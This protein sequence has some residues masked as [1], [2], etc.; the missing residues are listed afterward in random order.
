MNIS[1][2]RRKVRLRTRIATFLVRHK[3]AGTDTAPLRVMSS[4]PRSGT[5]WLKH[6][7]SQAMGVDP[8][9]RRINA[10]DP[11][12]LIEALDLEAPHR[13][14]YDHFD[15]DLH[16]T[17]LTPAKYPRLKVVLL[18]R[19]PVDAF[20]SQFY[21]RAAKGNL[22][23]PSLSVIENVKLYVTNN[24][25][26]GPHSVAFRE[27]VRR[28]AV[29]WLETGYCLPVRYE[30]LVRDTPG[31][32]ARVLDYLQVPSTSGKIAS[33]I[34]QNQ[35]KVLSGG[36]KPGEVDPASHYRRGLPGE[37]REVM[38]PQEMA[39]IEQQIGDYLTLLGYPT[40]GAV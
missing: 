16:S 19:H 2:L 20:I 5:H 30:D 35:F 14:I 3:S 15:Y 23:D 7:I 24:S 25:K 12:A 39:V 10:A 36:R 9:E 34:E 28:K 21:T 4:L 18:Y 37:W 27:Y 6:M 38:T 17:V 40:N 29:A 8:L 13:L 11:T 31:Q 1:S 33:A 32:L 26:P 22:P